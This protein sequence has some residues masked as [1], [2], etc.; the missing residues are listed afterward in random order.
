MSEL[1]SPLSRVLLRIVVWY[2]IGRGYNVNPDLAIDPDV[3]VVAYYCIL[4]GIW[5]LTEAW[6]ALARKYGWAQ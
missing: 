2:F 1:A 3:Q 4:G 6:W 5:L